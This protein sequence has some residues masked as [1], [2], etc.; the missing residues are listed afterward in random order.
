M[1]FSFFIMNFLK[2]I[3]YTLVV[4]ALIAGG[5]YGLQKK[6]EKLIVQNTVLQ[7][8]S[9]QAKQI[10]DQLSLHL[11]KTIT[12]SNNNQKALAEV[13]K[14]KVSKTQKTAQVISDMNVQ[15]TAVQS[16]TTMDEHEKALL[17]S[18]MVFDKIKEHQALMEKEV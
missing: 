6:N 9:N 14:A 3:I 16:D 10:N 18:Q 7:Q 11:D 12:I 15:A 1:D 5:I 4:I 8:Q 2:S 17:I 13:S